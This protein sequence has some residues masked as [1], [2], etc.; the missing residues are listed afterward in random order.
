MHNKRARRVTPHGYTLIE[1]IMVMAVLALAAALLVPS[2]VGSDTMTA[3]AAV[4]LLIADLSFAQSDALANQEYRRVVFFTDGSGY[5]I[6]EVA[7]AGEATPADLNDAVYVYDPL[8]TMGQYIVDFT[9]DDRFEGVSFTAVTIDGTALADRPEITYDQM[10]GT[11]L[12]DNTP[13]IGG[14]VT[15][16]FNGANYQIDIAPFTGKLTVLEL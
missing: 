15:L 9:V 4:R 3:Q 14:T 6:I 12:S 5:C 13:G 8:G 10:G 7:A 2:M 1:L 11:V 16:S